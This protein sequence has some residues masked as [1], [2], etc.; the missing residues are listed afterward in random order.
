MDGWLAYPATVWGGRPVGFA[1]YGSTLTL[2]CTW[3]GLCSRGGL[4]R[5]LFALGGL[6][7]T[8]SFVRVLRGVKRGMVPK[9]ALK[10]H[11]EGFLC[12]VGF[13]WSLGFGCLFDAI[14][15]KWGLG[16]KRGGE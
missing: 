15:L 16:K 11:M 4:A 12:L 14:A 9:V 5:C 3:C 2:Q 7:L 13:L 6:V 10:Y 8:I 1:V